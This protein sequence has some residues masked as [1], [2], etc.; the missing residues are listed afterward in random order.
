L[1]GSNGAGVDPSI[2]GT[3]VFGIYQGNRSII[4]QREAY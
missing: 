1:T 2:A 3:A 4:Y